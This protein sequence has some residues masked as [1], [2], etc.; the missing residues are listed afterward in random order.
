MQNL[1]IE[2]ASARTARTEAWNEY[3]RVI[4]RE[5]TPAE[6]HAALTK[7]GQ[8]DKATAD[9]YA[10]W[11]AVGGTSDIESIEVREAEK[12]KAMQI[13][14][15]VASAPKLPPAKNNTLRELANAQVLSFNKHYYGNDG[16]P[17]FKHEKLDLDDG[18]D[19]AVIGGVER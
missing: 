6:F 19:D 2:L 4:D 11:Q 10:R 18:L 9:L 5:H 15:D 13:V 1:P 8:A 16:L 7:A 12:R 14:L 17:Y 3:N